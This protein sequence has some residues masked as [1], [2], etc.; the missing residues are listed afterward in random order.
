MVPYTTTKNGAKASAKPKTNNF[1][2]KQVLEFV[3]AQMPSRHEICTCPRLV[4]MQTRFD[5]CTVGGL[6]RCCVMNAVGFQTLWRW[7]TEDRREWSLCNPPRNKRI[8]L[9]F[10]NSAAPEPFERTPRRVWPSSALASS[11]AE[12]FQVNCRSSNVQ[13]PAKEHPVGWLIVSE[14]STVQIDKQKPTAHR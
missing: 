4:R 13:L 6:G 14:L 12:T 11:P 1:L 5:P 10:R 9:T 2:R 8:Q 3:V 7:I